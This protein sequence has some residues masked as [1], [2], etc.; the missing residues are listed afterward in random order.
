M[1]ATA[2]EIGSSGCCERRF[3]FRRSDF[4]HGARAGARPMVAIAPE[5]KSRWS[6]STPSEKMTP[7]VGICD[8]VD[9]GAV[10]PDRVGKPWGDRISAGASAAPL[11]RAF[12]RRSVDRDCNTGVG[13]YSNGCDWLGGWAS[14][15]AEPDARRAGFCSDTDCMGYEFHGWDQCAVV[16]TPRGPC[17]ERR[18]ELFEL[19]GFDRGKPG[20]SV[21]VSA[22]WRNIEPGCGEAGVDCWRG[23]VVN[24]VN[25]GMP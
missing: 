1:L 23:I 18:F 10:D 9:S 24:R 5:L 4:L 17:A 11:R 14:G 13:L 8:V 6:A 16:G 22:G 21:W 19:V 20:A 2:R 3:S 12:Y 25:A 7:A 15:A